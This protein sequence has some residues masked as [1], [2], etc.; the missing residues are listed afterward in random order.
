MTREQAVEALLAGARITSDTFHEG[1]D[2]ICLGEMGIG[3]SSSAALIISRLAPA[4]LNTCVGPGAGHS[5]EALA[6][7]QAILAE[8]AAR[9]NATYPLEVLV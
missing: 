7:K 4:S 1:A 2:L 5:P 9:S 6:H 8:A 3:N